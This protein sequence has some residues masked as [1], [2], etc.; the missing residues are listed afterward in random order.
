MKRVP[1]QDAGVTRGTTNP[2]R[3]G[4]HASGRGTAAGQG[5]PPATGAKKAWSGRFRDG[6]AEEVERFTQSVSVDRRLYRQDIQGS[7]AHVRMLARQGILSA[8]DARRIEAGLKR[9]AR[10]IR[11]GRFRF[12]QRLEDIH[13][14][15][16]ARLAELVGEEVGGKLHTGR[17]R[18]DQVALDARLYVREGVDRVRGAVLRLL[19]VIT[20]QA[21]GHVDVILPGYTHLQKAQPVRLAHHLLAYGQ[22]F[23][24]DEQR[25]CELRGRVDVMP[26]GAGALAGAGYPVDPQYVAGL[27]GFSQTAANSMDAVSDRDF[28]V[29]FC[30]SA[31][32][33][34]LHLS[35]WAE[36][37]ILWAT[38]A[39]GFVDLPD[40]YCTGSSMMP[41]KKNPDVL[42]LV[43]G[44]AGGVF[45]DLQALLVLMK[46]LPLTYNRDM[47]EDKG[48]LFHAAD[49]VEECLAIFTSLLG[50]VRFRGERMRAEAEQGFLNATDLADAL[51]RRGIPFRRA[52]RL[53][54]EAVRT[55]LEAGKR[56][57]D[58]SGRQWAALS[59]EVDGSVREALGLEAVVEARAASGGTARKQVLGKIRSGRGELKKRWNRL[60]A[61]L[62]RSSVASGLTGLRD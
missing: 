22:M 5:S 24:R 51:V 50:A 52:H 26:L 2:Q 48:A 9:I 49:T 4:K 28:A 1:K 18:N 34:L 39:F 46:G 56:L 16:E 41:Q 43:R 15:I 27:L 57:E 45:G 21:A 29:E 62:A 35:R 25:L 19:D 42:E 32:M 54:G 44:K 11:D 53:A 3:G 31:S 7:V 6:T 33:I 60:A 37:L 38:D 13:M 61:D 14:H 40:A 20:E 47:Q 59:P 12:T 23:L 10:E 36:E 8:A 55:C 17:S 58:L 30:F